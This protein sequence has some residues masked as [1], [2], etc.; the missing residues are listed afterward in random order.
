MFSKENLL[1]K[2]IHITQTV[3]SVLCTYM[4]LIKTKKVFIVK[5]LR[6]MSMQLLHTCTSMYLIIKHTVIIFLTIIEEIM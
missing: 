6:N 3:E 5:Y 1:E 4:W 2:I